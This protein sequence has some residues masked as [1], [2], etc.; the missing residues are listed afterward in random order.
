MCAALRRVSSLT[1]AFNLNINS[2][3]FDLDLPIECDDEYWETTN[4]EDAFKQPKNQSSRVSYFVWNIKI[5]KLIALAYRKAVCFFIPDVNKLQTHIQGCI[6]RIKGD[7]LLDEKNA[8]KMQSTA[9]SWENSLPEHREH[10]RDILNLLLYPTAVR[11]DPN[12]QNSLHYQQS[13]ILR[14]RYDLLQLAIH[15]P[16]FR[17]GRLS[18]TSMSGKA[19]SIS[20]KAARDCCRVVYAARHRLEMSLRICSV[21]IN[22]RSCCSCSP[23]KQKAAFTAALHLLINMWNGN[24]EFGHIVDLKEVYYSIEV[25]GMIENRWNCGNSFFTSFIANPSMIAFTLLGGCGKLIAHSSMSLSFTNSGVP[26]DILHG[27]LAGRDSYMNLYEFPPIPTELRQGDEMTPA[28]LNPLDRYPDVDLE[29]FINHVLYSDPDQVTVPRGHLSASSA[30]Y[31]MSQEQMAGL[32][33]ESDTFE[34]WFEQWSKLPVGNRWWVGQEPVLT[35]E[36]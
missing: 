27:I 25:L 18:I 24:P 6:K 26:S 22:C 5:N 29:S 23:G 17:R 4:P 19:L 8:E 16:L 13:V 12:C 11:W 34:Q 33:P 35:A 10:P 14:A 36:N 31:W 9:E 32:A 28:D 2:S 30:S 20:T 1:S 3:S 7:L 21:S 15:R